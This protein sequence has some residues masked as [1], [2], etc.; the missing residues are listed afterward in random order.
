M[1]IIPQNQ[2]DYKL[3]ALSA[4]FSENFFLY[5]SMEDGNGT[6][7]YNY[8]L[9]TPTLL[10]HSNR[11]IYIGW[12]LNGVFGTRKGQEYLEDIVARFLITFRD[13]K[14]QRLAYKP[15]IDTLQSQTHI[16]PTSYEL[17]QFKGLKSIS[18]THKKPQ[19]RTDT[20][21]DNIFW[22]I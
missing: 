21:T 3:I 4:I 22:A 17:K 15:S 14:A 5:F 20:H 13:E 7:W 1:D 16:N 10:Y 6:E 12:A 8:G 9:P 18:N 11:G 19:L 2:H